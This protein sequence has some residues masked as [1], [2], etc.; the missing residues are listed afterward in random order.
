MRQKVFMLGNGDIEVNVEDFEKRN[1]FRMLDNNA[2][3]KTRMH[4]PL[5]AR[6]FLNIFKTKTRLHIK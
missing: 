1:I 6:N 5:S 3:F 2:E 4:T